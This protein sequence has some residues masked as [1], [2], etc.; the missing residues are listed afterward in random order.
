[1]RESETRR[2]KWKVGSFNVGP[3]V[4]LQQ[5]ASFHM[6]ML[7]ETG[8]LGWMDETTSEKDL[9]LPWPGQDSA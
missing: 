9:C 6:W 1:M 2:G 8:A 7:R 3:G 4:G 5:D